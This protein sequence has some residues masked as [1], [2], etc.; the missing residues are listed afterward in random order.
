[1]PGKQC[2]P[3]LYELPKTV[4]FFCIHLKRI[5]TFLSVGPILAKTD[6]FFAV[7][8]NQALVGFTKN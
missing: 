5:E 1:M 3:N 2:K 4:S 6:P 7:R 8:V